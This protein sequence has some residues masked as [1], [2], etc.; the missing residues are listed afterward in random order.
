[1]FSYRGGEVMKIE[2]EALV[3]GKR[4]PGSSAA[5]SSLTAL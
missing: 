5:S 4:R 3:A 2:G 1:M